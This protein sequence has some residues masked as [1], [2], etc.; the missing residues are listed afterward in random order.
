MALPLGQALTSVGGELSAKRELMR[1]GRLELA[2]LAGGGYRL[3]TSSGAEWEAV[4]ANLPLL[5]GINLRGVDQLVFGPRVGWQR[6]Y[7]TGARPVDIPQ[8][9]TTIGYAWAVRPNLTVMPELSWLYSPTEVNGMDKGTI[10]FAA[11]IGFQFGH[12]D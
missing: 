5:V 1:S 8:V 7:S 3:I 11:G 10:L 4:Y 9:G 2:V 12:A 6:W